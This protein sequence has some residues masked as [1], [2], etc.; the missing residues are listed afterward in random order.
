MS[1]SGQKALVLGGRNG[2][3][4]SALSR[5]LQQKGWEVSTTTHAAF[6]Y[7]A[8]DLPD[9]IARL[10]DSLEPDLVLNAVAYTDVE[11]AESE[12]DAAGALNRALPAALASAGKTRPFKLVHFSTDFVFDGLKGSP[13]KVDDTPVPRSIYGKTK[14]EGELAIKETDPQRYYIVRTAWLFGQGKVNFITKILRRC[15]EQGEASVVCDQTGSPTY[16]SDL[17]QYTFALAVSDASKGIYHITNSGQATWCELASEAV[18]CA[19]L[20]CSV[21]PVHS[22]QFI[23]QVTRP[24]F[25]VLDCTKFTRATGITPRSWPQAL[26]EYLLLEDTLSE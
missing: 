21:T 2:M 8:P 17:A 4:G 20:E 16:S 24:P 26:R 18:N 23:T 25:S 11:K 22:D 1:T 9:A 7:F 13:Y 6:N 5:T 12:P 15:R 3:L 19:Q 10:V 14:Y